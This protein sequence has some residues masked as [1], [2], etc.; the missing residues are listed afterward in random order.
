M[1]QFFRL[2]DVNQD[3]KIDK[4]ELTMMLIDMAFQNDK[5]L[6]ED[7]KIQTAGKMRKYVMRT[8]DK[9][10]D[11]KLSLEEFLTAVGMIIS[12]CTNLSIARL[13]NN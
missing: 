5:T 11:S 6:D 10:G 8:Y 1:F 13:L 7:E 3:K 2:H 4:R 9:D 12:S